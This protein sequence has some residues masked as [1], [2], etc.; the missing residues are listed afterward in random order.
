[1]GSNQTVQGRLNQPG[2]SSH[3][4]RNRILTAVTLVIFVVFLFLADQ[5]IILDSYGVRIIR[6]C[7][8]YTIA[9]AAERSK[10]IHEIFKGRPV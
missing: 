9:A 6:L 2:A 3:K 1:M 5:G 4:N 8:V 10:T 7:G